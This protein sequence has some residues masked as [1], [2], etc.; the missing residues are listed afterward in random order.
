MTADSGL[1]NR[2]LVALLCVGLVLAGGVAASA[3][4][5][6]GGSGGAATPDE[7]A[8]TAGAAGQAPVAGDGTTGFRFEETAADD[9][10][11][12]GRATL[13][14]PADRGV[15]IDTDASDVRVHSSDSVTVH[16]VTVFERRVIIELG[17]T[18]DAR[19]EYLEV[20]GLRFETAP[21]AEPAAATWALGDAGGTTT[22][23]PERLP[24]AV[25]SDVVR[26]GVD[27][28]P[29]GGTTVDV[30]ASDTR[31]DGHHEAGERMV[32]RVPD[33]ARAHL[34]FDQG[35]DPEVSIEGS[36]C[37]P[38]LL[39]GYDERLGEYTFSF[40]VPCDVHHQDIRVEGLRF[41]S[42]GAGADEDA[43]A[44]VRLTL[45]YAPTDRT[46]RPVATA[47]DPV[48]VVAPTVAVADGTVTEVEA[49]ATGAE[50]SDPVRVT[51]ADDHGDLVAEGSDVVVSLR[52]DDGV[53]FDTS[54][55]LAVETADGQSFDAS[56]ESVDERAVTLSVEGGS[57]AGESLTLRGADGGGVRFDAAADADGHHA[58]I[59]VTTN[60]GGDDVTQAT[61]GGVSVTSAQDTETATPTPT[62]TESESDPEATPTPT[63]TENDSEGSTPTPTPTPTPSEPA[64]P[65][66]TPSEPDDETSSGG[67]GGSGGGTAGGGGGS[68]GA[69]SGP[70]SGSD[71]GSDG[72]DRADDDGDDSETD[73]T[74]ETDEEVARDESALVSAR[75]SQPMP[76]GA[77][78]GATVAISF[79]EVPVTSVVFEGAAPGNVTVWMLSDLPERAT[80]PEDESLQVLRIEVPEGVETEPATVTFTVADETLE[81]AD[82]APDSVWLGRYDAETGEWERLETETARR[83]GDRVTYR[84]ETPGFS[85]FAIQTDGS[86]S[87]QDP[88]G[89]P[90]A[91]E[92][93]NRTTETPSE[94]PVPAFLGGMGLALLGVL[95]VA[96]VAAALA[97]YGTRV[98]DVDVPG[99]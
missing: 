53:T 84:A 99:R 69:S 43:D 68:G 78:A 37:E 98:M 97:V 12:G 50:G 32:L 73:E 60:A 62:E 49:G 58:T 57:A 19:E 39:S 36:D 55:D 18:D 40:E 64:T 67:S 10:E 5:S 8:V 92:T 65:T 25:E 11:S 47:A 54:Q 30:V 77:P 86:G 45:E 70:T 23:T 26:R 29:S 38:G 81:R 80:P 82:V 44:S 1:R 88:A 93:G 28:E 9:F 48:E 59:T 22:V 21:D 33:D 63:P 79:E 41:D 15:T 85:L 76:A 42:D 51:V 6:S 71:S 52:G 90:T 2:H 16:E 89:T 96:A 4:G 66:P 83:T 74:D 14:L 61:D 91:T 7:V 20:E 94:G 75:A 87:Y 56:V 31:T 35:A 95:F 46:G 13:T 17:A 3:V 27:G 34:A 72:S 24:V